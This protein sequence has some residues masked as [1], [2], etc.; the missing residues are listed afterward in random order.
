MTQLD[1]GGVGE[2]EIARFVGHKVGTLAGDVYRE[3]TGKQKALATSRPI[4][5]AAAVGKL[6]SAT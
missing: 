4:R 1:R 2:R 5:Y 6:A 3:G